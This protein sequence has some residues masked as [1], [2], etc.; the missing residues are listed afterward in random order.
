MIYSGNET[1]TVAVIKATAIPVLIPFASIVCTSGITAMV[2]VCSREPIPSAAK[3]KTSLLRCR[4]P[5]RS[6]VVA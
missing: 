3:S 2:S 6:I 4:I 1:A 5:E